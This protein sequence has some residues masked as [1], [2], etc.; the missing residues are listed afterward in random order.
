[1]ASA[2][3]K[4]RFRFLT[5]TGRRAD[6]LAGLV[7]LVLTLIAEWGPLSGDTT[8]GT[9]AVTQFYTWYSY[10]GESLRSGNVPAWNPSQ[11]S[12]APFAGDPLSGWTYLPAMVFFTLLP[13]VAAVKTYLFT[14]MLLA[15][16]FTYA[17]AR[18]LRMGPAGALL[19]AVV[20]EF[21]GH[22]F[23]HNICCFAWPSV[24]T[25]LPLAILGVELA[26]RST[27]WLQRGLWWGVSGLAVS[28]IL[29]SW[30]GQGTYYAL[31]ALGGYVLYRTLIS[32]P[33]NIRGI[34]G[35]VSGLFL[36]GA[37][38]LVFGFGL[39]A[40]GLLP[41]LEYKELSS[42]ANGY[43]K[44]GLEGN[45]SQAVASLIG[46]W[47]ASD[48]QQLFVSP[49]FNYVGAAVLALGLAAPLVARG[50]YA[51]P[52]FAALM[53][54]ALTLAGN[55]LTPLH[56]LLYKL[57]D[58]EQVHPHFPNRVM[59]VFYLGAALLA[60]AT[61]TDLGK[62]GRKTPSLIALPI[63]AA[64]FLLT[65]SAPTP[66]GETLK[67]ITG[68]GLWEG[69]LPFLIHYN[70]P[71]L[72]GPF[73]AVILTLEFAAAYALLPSRFKTLRGLV[74]LL[75]VLTV[76]F[77]LFSADMVTIDKHADF[78]GGDKIVKVDLDKYYDSTGAV[79][80]LKSKSKDPSRYLSYNPEGRY[81]GGFTNPDVRALQAENRATA[82][83]LQSIQGY[84][85]VHLARYDDYIEAL[86]GR[87]QKNYHGTNVY[88][89]GLGSPLLNL[90]NVRYITVPVT[91]A[92]LTD[93]EKTILK[94]LEQD[95]P[96]VYKDDQVRVLKNRD[97]MPRAWIVHS[98]QQTKPKDALEMLQSGKTDP[99][100]TVLLQKKPPA[101]SKPSGASVDQASVTSYKA[102]QIELNVTTKA[103]GMLML[104]EVY[105]PA[106]KAYVDGKPV[107]T[108]RADYLLRAVSIPAGKH[109]V[110][111]R[112][113]STPLRIGM[114]I[115]LITCAALI[116]LAVAAV[117]QHRRKKQGLGKPEAQNVEGTS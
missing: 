26:I 38:I 111:F 61:L 23:G 7:L 112:Y 35:R 1:M 19:A 94:D 72:A 103:P 28:Q 83:G 6:L 43:S 48:L 77:D 27:R 52:Y 36:H 25:W 60:G 50:R 24:L 70:V 20:Y 92:T 115:S 29:A 57:P 33:D 54:F 117:V 9:D 80:F 2:A 88:A 69:S 71:V 59:L 73:F 97:A 47:S 10:L 22:M 21:N 64:L 58:F 105:Y 51:V 30:L 44:A 63:M 46:G 18:Q 108:Y 8:V 81:V 89:S 39:A 32:P 4:L 76:F 62:Y 65:R 101:L 5:N 98:A 114:V 99:K 102:N 53:L 40:A 106:W 31:L 100:K 87:H 79:T 104:S 74:A 110:E 13:L 95:H 86:N 91:S 41:R 68:K 113:E 82:M 34:W 37:L 107:S 12:G 16:L 66:Q 93:K 49:G 42:L 56:S 45:H 15:G 17:L 67:S 11:F 75:L 84:N 55:G 96:T 90:L 78:E 3:R 14:H 85:P 109:T 116:S